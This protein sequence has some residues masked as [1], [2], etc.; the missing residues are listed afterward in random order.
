[1][2]TIKK[3]FIISFIVSLSGTLK[4][5]LA[6]QSHFIHLCFLFSVYPLS[7]PQALVHSQPSAMFCAL[8]VEPL[9]FSLLSGFMLDSANGR[10][11]KEMQARRKDWSR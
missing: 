11:L 10:H 9:W 3:S 7:H 4:V 1:M 2:V 6:V 5:K 8:G